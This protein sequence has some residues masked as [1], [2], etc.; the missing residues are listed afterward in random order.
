[1]KSD[2]KW[3]ENLAT[4]TAGED[5]VHEYLKR[6]NSLVQ[7]LRYQKHE[8]GSGPRLE[9]T[10]GTVILPDFAVYNKNPSKG[11]YAVDVK[12]KSSLYTIDRKK[13]FTVDKKFLDYKQA[14]Q[15]L[16][17][18]FLMLVFMYEDRMYFYKDTDLHGT[19]E[20]NNQYGTGTVYGFAHDENKIRY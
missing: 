1:M 16:K 7:D 6:N 13:C 20:Y 4:G 5:I 12:V 11:R 3:E 19:T 2:N 18:D 8:K 10:E 15:I 14:T 9:G 17:M